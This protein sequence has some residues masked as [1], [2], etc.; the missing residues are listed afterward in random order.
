MKLVQQQR[1][2]PLSFSAPTPPRF[3]I[4]NALFIVGLPVLLLISVP[5]YLW[6]YGFHPAE[7]LMFLAMWWITG[8][9][10][11]AGYHRLFSHRSYAAPAWLRWVLASIAAAACQN[12]VVR[13]VADHRKHHRYEDSEQDPYPTFRGFWH[14]QIAWALFESNSEGEKRIPD[15]WRD[16]VCRWQ[17]R[18]YFLIATLVNLIPTALLAW[19]TGRI[20]GAVLI[21]CLLRIVVLQHTTGLINSACHLWGQRPWS[22]QTNGRDNGFVALFTFGEGYH[23]YHHTHPS[24]YRN[25]PLWHHFDP[26]KWIIRLWAW[27]GIVKDLRFTAH[28]QPLEAAV[29]E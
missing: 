15:I 1:S 10:I 9:G 13:W 24:D 5:L 3:L 26:T 14:A 12:S 20:L 11:S 18:Y 4:I 29:G 17:H 6:H 28:P 16:P 27:L 21:G 22:K 25:G 19:Y 8:F 2:R 23:N 7:W